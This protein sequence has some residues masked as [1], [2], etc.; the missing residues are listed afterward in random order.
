MQE[1]AKIAK[2]I[3]EYLSLK[4]S[5]AQ[6]EYKAMCPHNKGALQSIHDAIQAIQSAQRCVDYFT[7]N[8]M[9]AV[10]LG[11]H[12][13]CPP[14]TV[15]HYIWLAISNECPVAQDQDTLK[16]KLIWVLF[17]I[18]RGFNIIN[19][20]RGADMPECPTG[21]IGLLV[22]TICEEQQKMPSS[23]YK[24][25]DPSPTNLTLALKSALDRPFKSSYGYMSTAARVNFDNSPELYRIKQKEDISYA[26]RVSFKPLLDTRVLQEEALDEIIDSGVDAWEPPSALA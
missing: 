9:K 11:N 2:E 16:E 13:Q 6:S 8:E 14:K 5:E 10:D 12:F 21:A 19:N 24:A 23:E 20:G 4:L 18:Q 15:L 17:Q 1:S 26:W 3:N 25:L 22:R 7:N